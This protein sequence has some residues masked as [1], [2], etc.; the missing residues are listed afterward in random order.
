M[1]RRELV[2]YSIAVSA[3]G[4]SATGA[5]TIDRR[6]LVKRHNPIITGFDAGSSLSV[7]NGCFAFTV[8][9]T[10]LQTIAEPYLRGV[11]L[12]T[13]AE[14]AWHTQPNP[15]GF[16]YEDTF[17][18]YVTRDGRK[19]RYPS[20]ADPPAGRWYRE[21]PYRRG[22][23]RVAFEP[24][25]I[26]AVRQE[27]DLWRGAIRSR[28]RWN[29]A[30]VETVTVCHPERDAVAVR[31]NSPALADGSLR[32]RF[33]FPYTSPGYPWPDWNYGGRQGAAVKPPGENWSVAVLSQRRGATIIRH[34]ADSDHYFARIH[35]SPEAVL[36]ISGDEAFALTHSAPVLEFTI[37]FTP[38][39]PSGSPLEA[40]DAIAAASKHW[41]RFWSSGAALDLSDSADARAGEMERRCV[42]SQYLTAI[43][44][45][46]RLPPQETGLSGNSWYGK[47]HGEMH[48]WHAAHFPLW[49]RAALLERSMPWYQRTLP[50]ARAY[51][52]AQGYRGARWPKMCG[53]EGRVSPSAIGA[54]LIWQQPHLI[55]FAEE[56]YR[57]RPVRDTL[58]RYAE[59]VEATAEFMASFAGLDRGRYF[60]GPP[61]IPAQESYKS[62]ETFNPTFELCYWRWGLM[63]AQKWRERR[64][65][66]RNRDWDKVIQQ[67]SPLPVRNGVYI[68]AESQPDFWMMN[69]R[70]HPSFLAAYGMLPGAGMV[71]RE[72]M[73]KSF[74]KTLKEWPMEETW[75]WDY[76]MMAMT[77]TRLG[78]PE[79]AVRTLMMDTANNTYTANGHCY[80]RPRL[81]G[82]LP[83]NG[84]L[85]AA[86]AMMAAGYEGGPKDAPGFPKDGK[87]RVRAENLRPVL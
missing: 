9:C 75:S 61:V 65:L 6:A 7:G 17:E 82:Y 28:F 19:V 8:D 77:A 22:L 32:V 30:P 48:W 13:Q 29:G 1:T 83:G 25:S 59:I 58:E 44:C 67:I 41:E 37:E 40:A 34:S 33:L 74:H 16:R 45:S 35:Y 51:A 63:M 26:D 46:G 24:G 76:P 85:L 78:E 5:A 11:P 87:W 69:R 66:P 2:R 42:L 56:L 64:R 39:A 27:L 68:G 60:L 72:V 49:G 52:A 50:H 80:Q 53:P 12:A 23:A 4:R 38:E 3:I 73:R 86:L 31:V 20:K 18:E 15:E 47:F 36:A 62:R 14:W 71:D 79:S 70:D 57:E 55:Y 21:N 84:G 81:A 43:Q 10:G 54:F